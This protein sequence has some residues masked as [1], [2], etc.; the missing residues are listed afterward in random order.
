VH[1][2]SGVVTAV[3]ADAGTVTIDVTQ[4]NQRDEVTCT[5]Q[6]VIILPGEGGTAV[7]PTYRPEDVPE[8]QAP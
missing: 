3:D 7:L 1:L 6:A 4:V 2:V 5:G 8:A